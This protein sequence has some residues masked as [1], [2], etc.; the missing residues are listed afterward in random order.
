MEQRGDLHVLAGWAID[1]AAPLQEELGEH[2][3]RANEQQA[4]GDVHG[5]GK[6]FLKV[7]SR[8]EAKHYQAYINDLS[9]DLVVTKP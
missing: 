3:G 9:A 4:E 8:Q 7:Q 6:M 5:E 2:E 1:P